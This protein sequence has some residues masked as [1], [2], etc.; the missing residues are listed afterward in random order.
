MTPTPTTDSAV[1]PVRE[2]KP[3]PFCGE[4]AEMEHDETSDYVAFHTWNVACSQCDARGPQHQGKNEAIDTWNRR[5]LDTAEPAGWQWRMRTR[6]VPAAPWGE[7]CEWRDGKANVSE[8]ISSHAEY[9]ERPVFASRTPN[10]EMV[11]KALDGARDL[12][13]AWCVRYVN[14]MPP[15]TARDK[16]ITDILALASPPSPAEVTQYLP[17]LIHYDGE[18]D[19][20]WEI[21]NADI[22]TITDA[23]VAA[24]VEFIRDM[25]SR[26]VIGLRVYD[27]VSLQLNKKG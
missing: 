15:S 23:P 10:T 5:F 11:V 3:C 19:P 21:V 9:E 27:P 13:D 24:N 7:W 25:N 17:Q 26:E 22:A 18:G 14:G 2:L 20:H 8:R 6:Q 1:S 12:V 4:R 16:L